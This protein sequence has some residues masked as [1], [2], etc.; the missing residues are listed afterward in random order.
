MPEPLMRLTDVVKTYDTGEVP[1]TALRGVNLDVEPASSSGSSASR[2]AG[3]TTLI[4]MITGI[5]RPTSGQSSSAARR[6]T[7]STRTS[8][9]CGAARPSASCSSSSSC[10]PTLTVIENVM[11]PMDF[12]SVYTADE[13][14]ERAL[15]AARAGRDGRP[16]LQAALG[17]LRRPAAARRHRPRARQRPADHSPPTSPPATSTPRPPTRCSACSSGSSTQGKTIIMVTHDND[18]AQR[19]R[20][21]LHV[22]RRRDRR[23]AHPPLG[24]ELAEELAEESA[25]A[26]RAATAPSPRRAHRRAAGLIAM[27]LAPR[28]HKV[29]RDL[30]GHKLRT[31]LVVLSIAVGIFA[32]AVV[33]GGRGVLTARVRHRLRGERPLSRVRHERLR[34]LA[35][36]VTRAPKRCARCGGSPPAHGPLLR[37]RPRPHPRPRD[38]RRCGVGDCPSSAA[39]SVQKLDPGGVGVMASGPGEVVLE[40]SVLQVEKSRDRRDDHGRDRRPDS[41]P[42]CASSGIAH[43]INAVPAKFSESRSGYVVDGDPADLKQPEKFNY[44]SLSLDRGALAGR[45]E[46]D[47]RRRA[48]H[49]TRAG[50]R[51]GA[52]HDGAQA[53]KPLPRRHLQGGVAAAARIGVMA[54]ALSGFLVVTTVSAIMAQQVKQVG[55]MKA[56]GGRWQQVMG[57]YLALVVIYGVLAVLVGVPLA[58]WAR[59]VVHRVRGRPAELPH[60]RLHAAGLRHRHRDR[61]GL[62][63]PLARGGSAGSPRLDDERREGAQRDGRLGELRPRARRPRARA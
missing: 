31:V 18:I 8:S 9:P 48:R 52:S 24:T 46:S 11:L 14:P 33:M 10:C 28:W 57:M 54:L 37:P 55:I 35:C 43:D 42:S 6:C 62:L 38:G 40:K 20:R 3:K 56:V 27:G 12:C 4:N 30:T 32:V 16:G 1:F 59:A 2:A 7:G 53:G 44:L 58:L 22:A 45:G 23:G 39:S 13:R 51:P 15:A 21:S 17:A 41:R 50:G 36:C 63:V 49:V 25:H 47:R 60:H 34:R 26:S 19:V 61:R 5:D 29:I